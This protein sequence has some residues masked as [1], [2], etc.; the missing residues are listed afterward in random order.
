MIASSWPGPG[1]AGGRHGHVGVD[2][3]GG[4]GGAGAQAG[5]AGHF[6]R[7]AAH[8]AAQGRGGEVQFF[9]NI[10]GQ[11]GVQG[12]EE[13][14]GGIAF[15]SAPGAF[16]A[17]GAG[18]LAQNA[19]ELPDDPVAALHNVVGRLH[20]LP[21]FRPESARSSEF[22]TRWKFC[23]HSAAGTA[24]PAGRRSPSPG[25]RIFPRRGASTASHRRWVW[26]GTGGG[27]T[28]ACPS[29]FTGS[30]VQAVKSVPTPITSSAATPLSR[31]TAGITVSST[32]R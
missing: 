7:N 21:G 31:S 28:A 25:R 20:R 11:A 24:R 10:V 1:D 26:S 9:R 2:D 30:T 19:G 29:A 3:G 15:R 22:P 32:S 13:V 12:F 18:V 14:L 17:G 6:L 5:S 27:S 4:H 8:G 23:R 16:V